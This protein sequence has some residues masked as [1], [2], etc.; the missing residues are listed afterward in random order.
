MTVRHCRRISADATFTPSMT[1]ACFIDTGILL[2]FFDRRDERHPDIRRLLISRSQSGTVFFTSFQNLAEFWNVSTRPAAARGGYGHTVSDTRRRL[3]V[4]ER[5]C[6]ILKESDES[7]RNW[8]AIVSD[9]GL[10]GVS[11]HDARLVAVMQ[12]AAITEIVTLNHSDFMRF[13]GLQILTP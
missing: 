7:Y 8:K 5:V 9:Y 6:S 12:A 2:R 11:V 4:I 1:D 10:T 13:N 3:S